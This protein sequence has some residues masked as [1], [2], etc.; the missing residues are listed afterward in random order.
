MED[1]KPMV[2]IVGAG[3][4]GLNAAEK[5]SDAP[6]EIL[7][8]D[9][10]NYHLFQPLLYQVAV[11]GLSPGEIAYPVRAIS[12]NQANLD[13]LLAEVTGVNFSER[14]L[15]TSA[16]LVNYD[17]LILA[18][19][20]ETNF[21]GI[22]SVAEHGFE[23]KDLV[24]A[25]AIRN[26]ILRMFE[27][28]TRKE[29]PRL[30]EALRTFVIV[31]GGPTGVECAGALSEL[32][33]LVL[34]KDYPNLEKGDARVLILEMMDNLLPGLPEEMGRSAVELL[35]RKRVE[36]RLGTTVEDYD[37]RQV[38][39]KGGEIIPANTLIWAAGV[40]AAGIVNEIE[41]PQG[42][43]SRVV[44]EKTLQL[45]GRA[46]VFVIGDAAYL[47]EEGEPLPMVAPVAIQQGRVVAKNIKRMVAG[48]PLI[49]FDFKDPGTLVTVGRSAGVARIKRFIFSG[50][51]AW[52]LWL[53][54]HLFW[55]IGFRNRLLV[56]INWAWN[57]LFYES[58]VRII[59]PERTYRKEA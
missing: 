29:D 52:L 11:A 36:V 31:G 39:L 53:G 2:V 55:L 23:L 59:K 4:A 43:Q 57:Y 6:V 46:E 25:E 32:I 12:R 27:I 14:C 47:E 22:D 33:R 9:K 58:A 10:R 44:V 45:T 3:F 8:I 17:Y 26:H 13:F 56:L 21:F 35:Q 30:C 15:E 40:K 19:G 38:I 5:L 24:D 48:K 41:A 18:V 37:G 50:F 1:R 20:G 16:G 42:K 7:L 28:A 54:V 49:N 51:I 34:T